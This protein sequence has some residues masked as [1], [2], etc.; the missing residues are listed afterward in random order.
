M[1]LMVDLNSVSMIYVKCYKLTCQWG[2]KQSA[3]LLHKSRHDECGQS[4]FKIVPLNFLLPKKKG[5]RIKG[6]AT[7]HYFQANVRCSE[8][9]MIQQS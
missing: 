9:V 1:H 7:E 3:L 2:I 4:H 5:N 8:V 6:S